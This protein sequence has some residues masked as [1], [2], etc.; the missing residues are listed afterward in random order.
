[1]T[2]LSTVAN[3]TTIT[4]GQYSITTKEDLMKLGTLNIQGG[5]FVLGADIDM[6]GEEWTPIGPNWQPFKGEFNGNGHTISNISRGLF[7]FVENSS[8]IN[9]GLKNVN[10]TNAFNSPIAFS[11][12]NTTIQNFYVDSGSIMIDGYFCGGLVGAI[13]SGKID[14]CWTDIDIQASSLAAN[15]GL[16]GVAGYSYSGGSCSSSTKVEI[17]NSFSKGRVVNNFDNGTSGGLAGL[18]GNVEMDNCYTTSTVQ[19]DIVANIGVVQNPEV[20]GS[21][22]TPSITN[23]AYLGNSNIDEFLYKQGNDIF[24]NTDI[25]E[26]T[27]NGLLI[28]SNISNMA[29]SGSSFTFQVGINS[30]EDSRID[31]SSTFNYLEASSLISGGLERAGSLESIDNFINQISTLQTKLG[32]VENRLM[33][34]LESIGVNI[35]NLT[36][37]RSTLK[38]A[39]VAK[40]SSSYIRSQILQQASATLLATAN[41]SP[42]LTLRLLGNL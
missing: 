33:S 22:Y 7:N 18:I 42:D 4:S 6:Q 25:E 35:E 34:N 17:T 27:S 3:G 1:M 37:S 30:T 28:M 19:S 10:I 31:V 38:D 29:G 20:Y 36:S 8:I 40:E 9:L 23:V 21:T 12:V 16:V 11:A 13:E 24:D 26:G 32:A 39:D 14:S 41:Q 5:E 15:G 2:A